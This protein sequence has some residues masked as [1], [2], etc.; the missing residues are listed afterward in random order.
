MKIP[1]Q[2]H[3]PEHWLSCLFSCFPYNNNKAGLG[4][5]FQNDCPPYSLSIV[6]IMQQSL[7]MMMLSSCLG[8]YQELSHLHI[9]YSFPYLRTEWVPGACIAEEWKSA[10]KWPSY[11]RFN[12]AC[13][14]FFS[15]L[16]C[17]RGCDFIFQP[18]PARMTLGVILTCE[19][20]TRFSTFPYVAIP[21]FLSVGPPETL[22]STAQVL[23]SC[24]KACCKYLN[25]IK[26]AR[27]LLRLI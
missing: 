17:I 2:N 11:T 25:Y 6:I 14:W 9:F 26:F 5:C 22:L 3:V 16:Y 4:I 27:N 24:A 8:L 7:M 15:V 20:W 18:F 21:I 1:D 23:L 12:D 13:K 19:R 10:Y